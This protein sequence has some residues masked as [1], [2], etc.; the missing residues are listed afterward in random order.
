MK[1]VFFLLLICVLGGHKSSY[2]QTPILVLDEKTTT[3]KLWGQNGVNYWL[4][5]SLDTATTLTSKTLAAPFQSSFGLPS[6]L[7]FI[8][9][10]LWVRFRINKKTSKPIS[11]VLQ[12][13]YPMVDEMFCFLVNETT[14]ETTRQSLK[15]ALP[16]YQRDINVHQAAFIL[17][18]V[19]YQNYTIYVR[20]VSGDAKK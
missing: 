2:A 11:W 18:L 9:A 17:D 4:D 12:N 3:L 10:H 19:P 15:E 8:D 14:G 7:G 13:D 20:L 1:K 6:N 5:K 16:G